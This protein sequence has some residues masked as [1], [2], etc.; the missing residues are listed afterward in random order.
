[1]DEKTKVE[2]KSKEQVEAETRA[3]AARKKAHKAT[4]R[5]RRVARRAALKKLGLKPNRKM[6]KDKKSGKKLVGYFGPGS[7]AILSTGT[8]E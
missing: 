6:T 5:A 1:M 8:L 3:E 2:K 7:S 4:R